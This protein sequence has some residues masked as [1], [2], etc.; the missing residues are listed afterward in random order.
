MTN[1]TN[2]KTILVMDDDIDLLMQLEMQLDAAGYDVCTAQTQDEAEAAIDDKSIDLAILDLMV[3]HQD[4]G[5]V[6]CYRI[7]K[8]RPDLPIILISAV[9][10]ETGIEFDAGTHEERSWIKADLFLA[11]PLRQEQLLAEVQRLIQQ[12]VVT[13]EMH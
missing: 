12:R 7:R 2:R 4:T 11:K 8:R 1:E 9:T 3:D 6:L 13:G 10:S 5:F